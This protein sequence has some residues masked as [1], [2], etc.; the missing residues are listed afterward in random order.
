VGISGLIWSRKLGCWAPWRR[1]RDRGR[2]FRCD[3]A[4]RNPEAELDPTVVSFGRQAECASL[5]ASFGISRRCLQIRP[6]FLAPLSA[7][8]PPRF[9]PHFTRIF[10]LKPRF[11][12][13]NSAIDSMLLWRVSGSSATLV[14]ISHTS[15][16]LWYA[17]RCCGHRKTA[18]VSTSVFASAIASVF[19]LSLRFASTTR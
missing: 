12:L 10:A 16:K 18:S 11:W 1:L 7:T 3:Y 17:S 4:A 8:C 19:R 15:A 9:R 5:E 6:E 13:N 2:I 14:R